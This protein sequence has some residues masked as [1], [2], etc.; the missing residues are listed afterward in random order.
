MIHNDSTSHRG[1]RLDLQFIHRR[2]RTSRSTPALTLIAALGVFI[3]VSTGSLSADVRLPG[4]FSDNMVLQQDQVLP[5][6]GWAEDGETVTVIF[7]KQKAS[8]VAKQGKWMVRLKAEKAGGPFPFQVSGKTTIALQNVMVGEVWICS[9]Q[10]NME[11]PLSRSFE[12]QNDIA[13]SG[14]NLIRLFTVP[15]LKFNVPVRDVKASWKVCDPDSVK[16]FSAV[17]YY[18]GR[19]LQKARHVPVGIIHTSWG[20][21][22]AE[23]WMREAVLEANP[24]YQRDI[25]DAF[26]PAWRNYQKQLADYE[27][28]K[29]EME[30]Q[31]RKTEKPRPWP[32]WRPCE[33]YNGMIAPLIPFAIRGAIWYQGESNAGRAWQYRSLFPDMISNWRRDWGQGDFTFLAVQL[34]PFMKIVD[35]PQESAWAEL[36]EAQLLACSKIPKVGMAVITDVGD[37]VDIHPTKKEPVGER[38]S[39]AARGIAYRER[40]TYSGPVYRQAR[41]NNNQAI[42]S[43]NHVG[44]GLEAR[45]G[46]LKGFA[47]CGADQKFIWASAKIK[48]NQVIVSSPEVAH[49]VAVRYGWAD[50]PVVNLWNKDGL[51]ATPF[52]TDNFPMVTK[53]KK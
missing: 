32:T 30:K 47:L 45:D 39:L 6:W 40:I 11:W 52:R 18:F 36:R 25:L 46:E 19:A 14:N 10:S 53:P 2:P 38:L 4:V 21:S 9:G 43:F 33:L 8:T 15:K 31:G 49:P 20:G 44:K 16:E 28:D 35:Q 3:L 50:C 1:Q 41:F 42:L 34:A 12:S 7:H 48:G 5:V 17:G 51:P 22:P 26:P 13:A 24:E 23:V 37:P 27:R 29:A